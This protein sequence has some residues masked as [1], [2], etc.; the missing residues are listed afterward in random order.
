[1]VLW[2][3]G[4]IR[5]ANRRRERNRPPALAKRPGSTSKPRAPRPAALW[6]P[7]HP[8]LRAAAAELFERSRATLPAWPAGKIN[9]L[10]PRAER[11]DGEWR[12]RGGG[13]LGICFDSFRRRRRFGGD[14]SP[15]PRFRGLL[16][17]Y[18]LGIGRVDS[19]VSE[20]LTPK[21]ASPGVA[22]ELVRLW[23]VPPHA[24]QRGTRRLNTNARRLGERE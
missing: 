4:C 19:P 24:E 11:W 10:R 23:L 22:T 16:R 21:M 7:N 15:P 3:R 8:L 1:M 12:G 6:R 14:S 9:I 5:T 13:L 17:W 2:V 18:V 20:S